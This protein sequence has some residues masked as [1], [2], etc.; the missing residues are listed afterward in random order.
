MP[1]RP[2]VSGRDISVAGSYRDSAQY[3]E[4]PDLLF[5]PG[6]SDKRRQIDAELSAGREPTV[7]NEYRLHWARLAKPNGSGDG[8]AMRF[9]ARGYVAVKEA[10]I[11]K[12]GI[13]RMESHW[14]VGADGTI[15]N[16]DGLLMACPAEQAAR[17][18]AVVRRAIDD[19]ASDA[20]TAAALHRQ[21]SEFDRAGGLTNADSDSRVEI[22]KAR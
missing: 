13:T 1:K 10:D 11:A 19:Q 12:Y 22:T 6:Y 17:N 14:Q 5:V 20:N 18:E 9:A 16:G 8:D 21:G 15:R 3:S 2:L 7:Q 4:N